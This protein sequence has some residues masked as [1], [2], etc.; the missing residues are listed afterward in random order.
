MRFDAEGRIVGGVRWVV[1]DADGFLSHP[2][3]AALG[4][5]RFLLGWTRMHRFGAYA[6]LRNQT[7]NRRDDF[8]VPHSYHL[9]E[10]DA[11]GEFV[12]AAVDV[13]RGLGWGEQDQLVS[14]GEGRVGWVYVPDPTVPEA[15]PEAGEPLPWSMEPRSPTLRFAVYQTRE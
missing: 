2:Q 14:L 15:V 1:V 8:R 4:N 3:L 6:N 11:Y 7:G 10:V 5:D 12:S 9:A 13:D